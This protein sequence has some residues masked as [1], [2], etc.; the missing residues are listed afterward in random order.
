MTTKVTT[1]H[2][3]LAL[4]LDGFVARTD[5]SLDWLDKANEKVPE[6]EDTGFFSFIDR[7]DGMIMGRGS[8]ETMLKFGVWP[9]PFP[10]VVMSRSMTEADIPDDYKDKVRLSNK[11]PSDLMNEFSSMGWEKVYI[12]G[13]Q[14]VRSFL[15][16][17]LVEELTL[18][19]VP[20]LIGEGISLFGTLENGDIELEL[21]SSQAFKG[22][23]V[24]N[25]YRV[26]KN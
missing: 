17:G 18:T 1:G 7:M 14:L 25:C 5:H 19:I 6:T 16:E 4:S 23:M 9:Y 22:G 10:V 12:D 11:S 15:Q 26:L 21:L 8:F 2:V 13:G 24:Q 3:F 20:T